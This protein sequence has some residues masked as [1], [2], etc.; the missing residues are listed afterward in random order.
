M[1]WLDPDYLPV[2]SGVI[3][4]FLLNPHGEIDGMIFDD[5]T[6]VHFPRICR[7]RSPNRSRLATR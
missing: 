4:L 6:E 2:T 5:G 3:E 1:H 7:A